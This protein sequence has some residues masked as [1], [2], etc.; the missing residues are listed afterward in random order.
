[1]GTPVKVSAGVVNNTVGA[2]TSLPPPAVKVTWKR[3]SAF[4]EISAAG[5]VMRKQKKRLVARVGE[6]AKVAVFPRPKEIGPGMGRRVAPAALIWNDGVWMV[7]G[8]MG[9]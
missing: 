7:G 8:S 4:P 5:L 6:G 9:S 1:M 3:F 2:V